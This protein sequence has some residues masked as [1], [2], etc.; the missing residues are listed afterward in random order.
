MNGG[1]DDLEPGGELHGT[2]RRAAAKPRT[3]VGR[4]L[5]LMVVIP[6]GCHQPIVLP[7]PARHFTPAVEA[8][9]RPTMSPS[10]HATLRAWGIADVAAHHPRVAFATMEQQLTDASSSPTPETLLAMAELAD[11]ISRRPVLTHSMRTEAMAWSR[12]AAVYAMFCVS[13]PR[14]DRSIREMACDVHNH[15]VARILRLAGTSSNFERSHWPVRLAE[16]RILPTAGPADWRTLGFDQIQNADDL[17]I[18]RQVVRERRGGLGVPVLAKRRLAE[19][20]AANWRHYGPRQAAFS[21]SALIRPSSGSTPSH[22]R[23]KP[24]ELVLHDPFRD[25]D[26]APTLGGGAVPIA[27]D[28]TAPMVDR[29][30]EFPM[31]AYQYLGIVSQ[32]YYLGRTGIYAVDPYQPGKIPFVLFQGLWSSPDEWTPMLNTLRADPVLRDKFQF[33]V[34]LY[35]SGYVPPLAAL[36]LR[37]ALREIRDRFDPTHTDNALDRMVI[38]GKSS[39]GLFAK[40]LVQSSGS[41]LWDTVFARPLDQVQADDTLRAEL[42]AMFF[43]E[44]EPSIARVIFVSTGHRGSKLASQPGVRAIERVVH[45]GDPVLAARDR[46]IAE[47]GRDLFHPVYRDRAISPNDGLNA[48]SPLMQAIR[49]TPIAPNVVYHSIIG[50]NRWTNSPERMTD[51]VVSYASAHIEGAASEAIIKMSHSSETNP[52]VIAEVRRILHV[53][54]VETR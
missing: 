9:T 52:D 18:T 35:P 44:P 31:L 2:I 34:A 23:S 17:L 40:M 19:H 26:A 33:W 29:L 16:A 4:L 48:D 11:R 50:N 51:G 25:G 43:Y 3:I 12:D 22:W 32:S 39:G 5:L 14:S 41:V 36:S 30:T 15:A 13:D 54:L 8:I 7:N 20:D 38:L 6:L 37:R 47:N 24:V 45:S 42:A 53:H 28:L 10:T 1:R 27:W 46:L 49:R 21:A